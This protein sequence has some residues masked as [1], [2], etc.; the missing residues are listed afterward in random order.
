M[1]FATSL[2]PMFHAMKKPNTMTIAR[3]VHSN[4]GISSSDNY[5]H[6]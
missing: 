1:A 5:V 3:R 4:P 2:A 6:S